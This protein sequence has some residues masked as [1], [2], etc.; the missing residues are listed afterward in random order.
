MVLRLFLFALCLLVLGFTYH[1]LA[2]KSLDTF[3]EKSLSPMF[4]EQPTDSTSALEQQAAPDVGELPRDDHASTF[5]EGGAQTTPLLQTERLEDPENPNESD[6]VG[7]VINIGQF[8]DPGYPVEEYSA[9][10]VNDIGPV[11]DADNPVEEVETSSVND[12]GGY[13][14]PDSDYDPDS[15]FGEVVNLGPDIPLDS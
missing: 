5:I 1:E 6:G 7:H 3:S 11:L 13:I 12:I 15:A 14:D 8:M 10:P 4:V 9:V 2:P